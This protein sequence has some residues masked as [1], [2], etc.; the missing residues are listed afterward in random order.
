[1]TH[2]RPATKTD[3]VRLAAKNQTTFRRNRS[4]NGTIE[5]THGDVEA[6]G[7]FLSWV[8]ASCKTIP[9]IPTALGYSYNQ[10]KPKFRHAL[11]E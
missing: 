8:A 9:T 1:M 7:C 10:V 2:F 11:T 3:I 4:T 5:I 6:L